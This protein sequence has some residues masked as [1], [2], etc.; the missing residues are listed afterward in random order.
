[1]LLTGTDNSAVV[2]IEPKKTKKVRTEAKIEIIDELIA[3][4]EAKL[5]DRLGAKHLLLDQEAKLT[6]TMDALTANVQAVQGEIDFNMKSR[7]EAADRRYSE[8]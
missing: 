7:R 5:G 6:A 1:M 4:L 8:R 2:T 3:S